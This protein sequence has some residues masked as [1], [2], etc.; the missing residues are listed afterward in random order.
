MRIYIAGQ[1]TGLDY[2]ECLDTFD[3][4]AKMLT[5]QGHE[6]VNP[7]KENGLDGDGNAHSWAEYM[8]RDI[9][10]LLSCDAIYL[11][12]NWANSK[13]ATLEHHIA[14]ALGMQIL[15]AAE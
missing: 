3:R 14:A 1:I 13:G 11:M 10:H 6:P 9:P 15:H 8:R 5:E 12:T 7:M 4:T 2:D